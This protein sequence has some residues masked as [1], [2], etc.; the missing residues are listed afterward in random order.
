M[1]Y[2]LY[3]LTANEQEIVKKLNTGRQNT[4]LIIMNIGGQIGVSAAD[5]QTGVYKD[6]LNALGGVYNPLKVVQVDEPGIS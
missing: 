3:T 2:A 6:Y 4:L 5:I 1:V